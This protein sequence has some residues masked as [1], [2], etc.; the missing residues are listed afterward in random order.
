MF[1]TEIKSDPSFVSFATQQFAAV[2]APTA[3]ALLS[4]YAIERLT[5]DLS[6]GG[7]LRTA[8]W[9]IFGWP[10]GFWLGLTV[11]TSFPRSREAGRWVWVLPTLAFSLLSIA[12]LR[13][14]SFSSVIKQLFFASGEGGWAVLLLTY[15]TC[16][17]ILYSLA[18]LIRG[19][20]G[21]NGTD[22]SSL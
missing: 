9:C 17:A 2:I 10:A 7:V 4:I 15:P 1:I 18:M 6:F 21:E 8:W 13:R 11:R 12:E 14:T 16:A 5:Q 22:K 19:K 20:P 3:W